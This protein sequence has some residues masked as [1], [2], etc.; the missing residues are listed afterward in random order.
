MNKYLAFF[1]SWYD[2][3]AILVLMLMCQ[4]PLSIETMT[5]Q[6]P[7]LYVPG[8]GSIKIQGIRRDC[9]EKKPW[10]STRCDADSLVVKKRTRWPLAC[11]PPS[12]PSPL[13]I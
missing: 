11:I 7:I 4:R 8:F 5:R 9:E 3:E 6:R 12:D 1:I 10:N 2:G 13:T